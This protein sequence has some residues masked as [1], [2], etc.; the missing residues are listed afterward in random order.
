MTA[1]DEDTGARVAA[2]TDRHG[3][4]AEHVDPIVHAAIL[5]RSFFAALEPELRALVVLWTL[6]VQVHR[7]GLPY[8][9]EDEP[10]WLVDDV[11][12]AATALGEPAL[13]AAFERLVPRLR[14]GRSG[15]RYSGRRVEWSEHAEIERIVTRH[16]GGR[17]FED[18]LVEI[19]LTRASALV[20]LRARANAIVDARYTTLRAQQEAQQ[21]AARTAW[22]RLRET[23]RPW[24][25][26]AR[27]EVDDGLVHPKFGL[28]RVRTSVEARITVDFEDG[29]SRVLAHGR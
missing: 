17:S 23:A 24:A 9:V 10:R 13:A 25:A 4:A 21:S 19:A 8:F 3:I 26:S 28:G 2:A 16:E 27:F 29:T 6:C 14:R 1:D 20:S 22:E 5:D 7:N 12:P 15:G 18:A 11:V